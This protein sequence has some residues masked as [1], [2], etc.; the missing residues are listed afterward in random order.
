MSNQGA[1]LELLSRVQ[2]A[3]TR[4]LSY[5]HQHQYPNGE[6]CVYCG[7]D[8]AMQDGCSPDSSIFPTALIASSL[9]FLAEEPGVEEMLTRSTHFFRAQV[10][11][12]GLWSHFT[13]SHASR[14]LCGPDRKS[15]V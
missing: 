6:F 15:V 13:T 8:P 7:K 9:L 1:D 3:V 2:Q 10:H 4:G 14:N 12:K 5:L 11:C